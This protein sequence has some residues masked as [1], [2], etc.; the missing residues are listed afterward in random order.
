LINHGVK[1]FF[2]LTSP[3]VFARRATG[4]RG[5]YRPTNRCAAREFE[6]PDALASKVGIVVTWTGEAYREASGPLA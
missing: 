6:S 5:Q 2:S 4:R 1:N 3:H